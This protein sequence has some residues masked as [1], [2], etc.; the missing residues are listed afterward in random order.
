LWKT[1]SRQF[2]FSNIITEDEVMKKIFRQSKTLANTE[3]TVMITGESGTGKELIARALHQSGCRSDAPF[4][5]ID[6]GGL[7]ETILE[8][9]IFGH[10]KG[11]FTGAY[12]D[13]KGY[14][15]VA[16]GGTVFFDEISE[17]PYPLQKKLLRVIQEKEFSKVGDTWIIKANIRILAATNIDLRRHVAEGKFREDLYYRLDVVTLHIPPLRERIQDIPLLSYHFLG[18]FNLRLNR[19]VTRVTEDALSAM[20]NYSWPGNIRELTNIVER[21]MTFKEN[22]TIGVD[23]LPEKIKNRGSQDQSLNRSLAD[24]KKEA[25]AQLTECYIRKVLSLHGGNVSRAARMAQMDRG[26]FRKLMKRFNIAAADF[27]P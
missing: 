25:M 22:D 10:V 15:E 17:L 20:M 27:R 26:N 2:P 18:E 1:I 24:I 7:P 4:V 19:R 12:C 5:V 3:S 8:S 13:K 23:D 16:E 11:A 6:C 14:L 9:E 21:I